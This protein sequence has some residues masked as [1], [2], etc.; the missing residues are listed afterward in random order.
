MKRLYILLS[1]ILLLTSCSSK[2][3]ETVALGPL[4][5]IKEYLVIPVFAPSN[6]S[7]RELLCNHLK[8]TLEKIGTV[9]VSN[10]CI[11]ALPSYGAGMVISVDEPDQ[12]KK[13]SIKILAEGEVL[14]N[15][16]KASC[17]VWAT[18][19]YDPT[20]PQ[21]IETENGIMF[22]KDETATSPDIKDVIAQMVTQFGTQYQHD[23]PG[24][25]PVFHIYNLIQ[26]S[27]EKT[28]KESLN[29]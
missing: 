14:I 26:P 6:S 4:S 28:L 24:S 25:K 5:K 11:N 16:Q 27:L 23:N 2:K 7:E 18:H 17:D 20:L 8:E 19:F 9:Y 1:I 22:K 21:L 10:D 12:H 3:E 13:G 15:K 29:S